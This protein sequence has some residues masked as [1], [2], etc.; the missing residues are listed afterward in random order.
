MSNVV[1]ITERTE[2]SA[3]NILTFLTVT[4]F[5]VLVTEKKTPPPSYSVP[6]AVLYTCTYIPL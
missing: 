3:A 1:W 5:R 4:F 2:Y 6:A